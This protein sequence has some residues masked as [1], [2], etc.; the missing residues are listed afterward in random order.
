MEFT[1]LNNIDTNKNVN[2]VIYAVNHK[3]EPIKM[4]EQFVLL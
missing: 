4:C 2:H 3:E 1:S